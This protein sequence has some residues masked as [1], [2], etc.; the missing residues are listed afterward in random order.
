MSLT[1]QQMIAVR[2]DPKGW[3]QGWG[4]WLDDENSRKPTRGRAN[5]LQRRVFEHYRRCLAER[6][7]CRMVV[8][9]YRRAGS[10][11]ASTATLYTHALNFP[12]TRLGVIGTD[13]KASHNMLA[14]VKTFGKH[15]TF[16]GWNGRAISEG[17]F[18]VVPWGE[19]GVK[20]IATKVEWPT[21][22]T[23][24]LYT[25][26]NPTSARSA[27]LSGYLATECAFWPTDGVTSGAETLTAMRN[28]LPKKGFH[29]CIEESTAHGAMGVHYETCKEA[30]WPEYADWWKKWESDWPLKDAATGPERDRQFVFIF[31]AW[32]ED[33]RNFYRL[34]ESEEAH[35]K[36]TIDAD[37]KYLGEQDLMDR[38]LEDGPRGKR[39]GSEVDATVWEQLLWRRAMIDS[40]KG[41]ENFKQEYPS[42]PLEAF[43]AT[44]SPVFDAEGITALEV[45]Q[46]EAVPW[47]G[48]LEVQPARPRVPVW[49]RVRENE[50]VFTKW[51]DPRV[52]CRY[53]VTV[54]T[55]SGKELVPGQRE[56]DRHS[57]LVL[58]AA[59]TDE[60][61]RRWM[62]K[63]VARIK[64]PCQWDFNPLA[65][66]VARLAFYYGNALTVVENNAG[67]PL[68]TRLR[69]DYH[70]R[71]YIRERFNSL[72]QQS[73]NEFGF[74]TDEESRREAI[75][76][77]Q[78][79]VREQ[80]LEVP[81]PHLL[82]EMKTFIFNKAGKAIGSGSNHDDD[83]MA[84]AIGLVCLPQATEYLA[85]MPVNTDPPDE[86]SW[87]KVGTR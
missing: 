43:R 23:V 82:G 80:K 50:A 27:G 84:L 42:N 25:A 57:A 47:W 14:M 30:R 85:E 61:R 81:C 52:G 4:H 21:G 7:P 34:T 16:A 71:L 79:Y 44:G 22:S 6:K 76:R 66:Q 5:V 24:E 67:G 9:K 53:L 40:T 32:F 73:A 17:N 55:M 69:D 1:P 72:T 2:R 35:V 3:F 62:A 13:Y 11:T 41:L 45:G 48:Q 77:A 54:D 78:E 46:R 59:F 51:E 68:I 15:D 10:S 36:E 49:V 70:V 29:V 64:A 74:A 63:V 18:E 33:D 86:R 87:R 37:P 65:R 8:L 28:T 60:Q 39:L 83:V 26:K 12:G 75:A 31:A 56:R 58:R 38:Y 19:S 20:E